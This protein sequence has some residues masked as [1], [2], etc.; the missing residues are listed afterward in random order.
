MEA[1][2]LGKVLGP[3]AP[4]LV[5]KGNIQFEDFATI[6]N[7]NLEE[8]SAKDLPMVLKPA[9]NNHALVRIKDHLFLLILSQINIE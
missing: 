5:A 2:L 7:L 4:S 9:M 6:R 8:R 1:G 3:N